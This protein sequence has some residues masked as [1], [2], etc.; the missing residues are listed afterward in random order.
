MYSIHSDDRLR[1]WR[2]ADLSLE[3]EGELM[4]QPLDRLVG[5]T[6]DCDRGSDRVGRKGAPGILYMTTTYYG[7]V[8]IIVDSPGIDARAAW[9]VFQHDPR[10][11]NNSSTSLE[12]FS[13]P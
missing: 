11:T 12:P 10:G 3:W 6:L 8:A 1:V 7:V 5:L 9:P 2:T 13:C 4:P